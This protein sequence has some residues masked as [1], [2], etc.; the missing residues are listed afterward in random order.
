MEREDLQV[1]WLGGPYYVYM[2]Q[3]VSPMYEARSDHDICVALAAR[4]GISDYDDEASDPARLRKM[5]EANQTINDFEAFRRQSFWRMETGKPFVAFAEEARDPRAH[6]FPTASGKIEL[7]SPHYAG[8]NSPA[9]PPVPKYFSVP[10][11]Y[12]DGLAARYPLQLLTPHHKTTT[13]SGLE[14]LPW[15]EEVGPK[16]L[17]LN[18]QDAAARAIADGDEVLV[19]NDRGQVR[20]K[21]WVARRIRPGVVCLPQGGWFDIDDS[22]VDRGGC[23][24]VLVG[25]RHTPGGAW[26]VNTSL[27]EVKKA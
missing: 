3:A 10:E 17:W 8:M 25:A 23:A 9:V 21:A 2:Q 1:P 5:V 26:A 12:D 18:S 22:G 19:F 14:K 11:G 6:P 27:V 20:I 15:L 13:H 24:N 7:F 4:L 16:R